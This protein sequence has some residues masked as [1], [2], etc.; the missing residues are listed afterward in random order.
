MEA[1]SSLL[2][3]T[4]NHTQYSK[5]IVQQANN[6]P[7]TNVANFTD[8]ELQPIDMIPSKDPGNDF[9]THG[10]LS[11]P[12]EVSLYIHIIYSYNTTIIY[13]IKHRQQ[14]NS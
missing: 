14:Q 4:E 5:D 8:T 3:L 12:A 10:Y 6:Q 11:L 13:C 1:S 7:S 2:I 9:T